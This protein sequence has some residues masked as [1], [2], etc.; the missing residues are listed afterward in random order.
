MFVFSQFWR[1]KVPDQGSA[2]SVSGEDFLPGLLTAAFCLVSSHGGGR[3]ERERRR[4]REKLPFLPCWNT[5]ILDL[6][7]R[8]L[9]PVRF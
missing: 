8:Q 6:S 3:K 9:L 1:P 4:E 7:I 5:Q 2:G